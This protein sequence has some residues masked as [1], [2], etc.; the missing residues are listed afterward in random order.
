LSDF[1][2]QL[3][4]LQTNYTVVKPSDVIATLKG[5]KSLPER[6]VLLTFDDG[7]K[8]H[9]LHV[10]PILRK[11]NLSAVFFPPTEAVRDRELL[12]VNRLHFILASANIDLL[13][14]ELEIAVLEASGEFCLCSLDEYRAAWKVSN[15][16]DSQDVI[17]FKR[18]LQHVLPEDLRSRTAKELFARHVSHDEKSFAD[19]LYVSSEELIE[20]H[21]KGLEVGS[22]GHRH[23]WLPRLNIASQ[24]KDIDNSLEFLGSLGLCKSDFWFCY[25]YGS[26]SDETMKVLRERGCAAAVTVNVDIADCVPLKALELSRLDTNDLPCSKFAAPLPWTFKAAP[27][28]AIHIKN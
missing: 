2:G 7:Y 18:M 12:D 6:A 23:Y 13:V 22:H 15:R 24:E 20:M 19:D 26:Y 21:E 28:S 3:D 16:F 4:Y 10:Y 17:Y 9:Y 1:E 11:R 14:S 8:D 5:L 27:E 25:P